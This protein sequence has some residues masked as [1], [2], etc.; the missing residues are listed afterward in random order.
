MVVV[1]L[2]SE[3]QY[4]P[5]AQKT[6]YGTLRDECVRIKSLPSIAYGWKKC[7][8]KFKARP[9]NWWIERQPW[10]IETWERGEKIAR[11]I[12]Y[13]EDERRRVRTAFMDPLE[14]RRFVPEYPLI[15]E[16]LD[17]DG[18]MELIQR[19][20]LPLPRK[21][22]CVFCPSNK[23]KEWEEYQR[24]YPEDFVATLEMSRNAE[25]ESPD[26]VGLMLCNPPGRRQLHLHVFNDGEPDRDGAELPCDCAL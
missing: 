13:D 7:S 11:A 9:A 2:A 22:A 8:Q 1:T 20:G 4:R 6:E 26:A 15:A 3:A 16:G 14:A 19:H 12:G 23:L 10:A 17:R 5:R 21:S 24:R 18:C 25:I